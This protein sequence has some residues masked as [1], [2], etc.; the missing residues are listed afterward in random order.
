MAKAQKFG[1]FGGVFTP[2]I[3]TILGVI[4]YLRLPYIV[5]EAGLWPTI[6][7]IV[8][9]HI[10]SFTTGLS[11][12][13]IATD[14]KVKAGGTYYMISRS[15]GLPIGGTLGLAL[16]VGLSFSVSL[17]LIGFAES[18]LNYFNYPVTPNNIRMAG[19][20][21]LFLVTVITFISTSL[22]IK[23]QYIIMAAILLSLVS[24]FAGDHFYMPD[25]P[26]M[27][28][29]DSKV[30]L[31]VLFGIFFPAVTGF[32]AGVSMSGDLQDPKRSIP[33]GS[34][35]AI[36]VGFVVYIGLAVYFTY[37][38]DPQA[39]ANPK[40]LFAISWDERL[41]VAGIWGAT[42]SSAL[43]SIL[44]A[45]RILQAT[46]VDR[47]SA[48]FFA[49]GYGPSN[50]P[51][52]ALLLTFAIAQA[53]ILIG[54]LDVIA[55]VVSVFFITTY[56]FLNLSCAIERWASADFRPEFKVPAWV[57]LIGAVSAL[58]VMILLD[59]VSTL[60]ASL[61]LLGVFFYLKRK[62]LRLESGDAWSG[63]WASLVKS[64]IEKLST[65]KLHTRNW[66]PNIIMFSGG[67]H[68][69]PHLVEIG[70][71]IAGRLGILSAFELVELT[72]GSD[73]P[74]VQTHQLAIGEQAG[75]S[76]YSFTHHCRN[77]YHGMEEVAR[78]YGFSGIEP[79]TILMG[80][81]RMPRNKEQFIQTMRQLRKFNYNTIFL[82]YHKERKYGNHRT[83]DL[84]WNGSG[85]NLSLA[86]NLIR[87]VTGGNLWKTAHIRLLYINPEPAHTEKVYKTL[88]G[89]I[90]NYRVE[91]EL[92]IIN[93]DTERESAE[94]IITRESS[95][96]DLVIMGI[97]E[98]HFKKL[99]TYYA[100]INSFL[101]KLGTTIMISASRDFEDISIWWDTR[102][103]T[104]AEEDSEAAV[105][106]L[107]DL[108]LSRYRTIA[109]DIERIDR[110]YS[111]VMELLHAKVLAPSLVQFQQLLEELY[112][113]TEAT[114]DGLEKA[115]A[116]E[117]RYRRKKA[118]Q[119][120]VN[121]F[122]FR[123]KT[124]SE[125][126]RG[127]RL[128]ALAL[129]L[130]EGITWYTEQLQTDLQRFPNGLRL[131]YDPE[132]FGYLPTDSMALKWFKFKQ[133]LKQFITG[134]QM[135][136]TI[137]YRKVART[138]LKDSRHL[139]LKHLLAKLLEDGFAYFETL[140]K[141]SFQ[142]HEVLEW[143]EEA[144]RKQSF[145]AE[146]LKKK[147]QLLLVFMQ[148]QLDAQK[149][150]P[151]LYKNRLLVE[152]RKNLQAMNNDLEHI[153]VTELA[154]EKALG[155][156]RHKELVA[157]NLE[158]AE[159]WEQR[160]RF[161][162]NQLSLEVSVYLVQERIQDEIETFAQSLLQLIDRKFVRELLRLE[163][164]MQKENPAEVYIPSA[165]DLYKIERFPTDV[166]NQVESFGE[167]HRRISDLMRQLPEELEIAVQEYDLQA[168][169]EESRLIPL[170]RIVE[171]FTE[172]RLIAP[173]H[174]E[175][176]EMNEELKRSVFAL[177]DLISLLQ[178]N[179][180]NTAENGVNGLS[181]EQTTIVKDCIRKMGEERKK[182][183]ILSDRFIEDVHVHLEDAFRPMAPMRM[184][185]SAAE[186]TQDIRSYQGKRV[187][188]IV[189]VLSE[190]SQKWF[191]YL[192]SRLFYSRSEGILLARRLS[193]E[194]KPVSVAARLLDLKESVMPSEKI[195]SYLPQYYV[196][197]FNG[198]SNIGQNFWVSKPVEEAKLKKAHQ[199]YQEGNHGGV[200]VLGEKN[201]GKT[202]FCRQMALQLFRGKEVYSVFPPQQGAI[203]EAEF[204]ETLARAT[205][206]PGAYV[207]QIM[208]RLPKDC[209]IIIHDLELWWERSENGLKVVELIEELIDQY[210][211]RVFF[212]VNMNPF[213]FRL[214]NQLTRLSDR[215]LEVIN[216][217]PLGAE[218]IKELIMRR[219][220]SA[221]LSFRFE[222]N[223]S[224][225]VSEIQMASLFNDY[226]DMSKGN[227]G[228]ALNGWLANITDMQGQVLV[229]RKPSQPSATVF[230]EL[231]NEWI[232]IL[233]QLMLHK[234]L[235]FERLQRVGGY[236]YDTLNG[237][238]LG[239][240]RA[241]LVAEKAPGIYTVEPAVHPFLQQELREMDVLIST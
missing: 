161:W 88:E 228:V 125:E 83:I 230:K 197:L 118:I 50:E 212:L 28:N 31:M 179:I 51:R 196:S 202:A 67:D 236:P 126:W 155:A 184:L 209:V 20:A 145:S 59:I 98:D 65:Q 75:D 87:H 203:E 127:E 116:I 106:Q 130:S 178:F 30:P 121:D 139:Y 204:T 19:S 183:K 16:F 157:S 119:K 26:Q 73:L 124:L 164:L 207:H 174:K 81:S 168:E 80:W 133:K 117:E 11:V 70:K 91:M 194:N 206:Q 32:E 96:T 241:G 131:A 2:S 41:V 167:T 177:R 55:R 191:R 180:D 142:A 192:L 231:D 220:R 165:A 237:L 95:A 134:G 144:D 49:K 24:I 217:Q 40:V 39:L 227:P 189:E 143:V 89:V 235:S 7:I 37:T 62:E 156:S 222:K 129:S 201:S 113:V 45:P 103:K 122:Y 15:L 162:A 111:K 100:N 225:D 224:T 149:K 221:G 92:L 6:G 79:N 219:H 76:F 27:F 171:H 69:R 23:T 77:V 104:S 173:M 163:D 153:Q 205:G 216:T 135:I 198:R 60:A 108:Q 57:S 148:N 158:Y 214:V 223:R 185:E 29:Y 33:G 52:N 94:D 213:A 90:E 8:V 85:R 54:E 10:I 123:L 233:V 187:L 105:L 210:S 42:L 132:D 195:I 232:L 137:P 190:R 43:G 86:I 97:T 152:F 46:A 68:S 13:S 66:R 176:E 1:T 72:D 147:T 136:G 18:F 166:L 110:N 141:I 17:Y 25:V 93:Q 208:G 200:M 120:W 193:K 84:W 182:V 239:L 47:I 21:M 138:Y 169:I 215:F 160:S 159:K 4:M 109:L 35:M 172:S 53:G 74:R 58:L 128:P 170:Q 188:S 114:F 101:E 211:H 112:K 82:D 199:R 107:P 44:G 9:A 226:F 151:A 154:A 71:A 48:P 99:E 36:A 238:V 22:A 38:V 61:L 102:K 234:R 146:E 64:G 56:G 175:L 181:E 78:L 5:G 63:I 150:L 34:I 218:E 115:A 140:K 186:F 12:S 3:L 14:K 229:I 240:K